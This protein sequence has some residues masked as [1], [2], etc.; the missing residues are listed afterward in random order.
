[1]AG[2]KC[3][4][5]TEKEAADLFNVTV[6]SDEKCF[7]NSCSTSNKKACADAVYF[8][9]E[10]LSI[11]LHCA[12]YDNRF[13]YS[14]RDVIGLVSLA[15][16]WDRKMKYKRQAM[17][18][19]KFERTKNFLV[20]LYLP[21]EE[22]VEDFISE[23][24]FIYVIIDQIVN[25]ENITEAEHPVVNWLT[26]VAEMPILNS[27]ICVLKPALLKQPTDTDTQENTVP[28]VVPPI[29]ADN[30]KKNDPLVRRIMSLE[31]P[32]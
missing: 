6:G 20:Q 29:S 27:M 9:I 22:K 15:T 2:G 26:R 17:Y 4:C 12:E 25:G 3:T 16:D 21:C 11:C 13:V 1:M 30:I 28:K 18:K 23:P 5:D 32:K 14:L 24:G 31:M 7:Q 10:H 8:K 19:K